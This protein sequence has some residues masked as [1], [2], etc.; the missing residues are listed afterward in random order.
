MVKI[1]PFVCYYVESKHKEIFSVLFPHQLDNCESMGVAKNGTKNTCLMMS[2]VVFE[3][4]RSHCTMG[5]CLKGLNV[6]HCSDAP[7]WDFADYPIN[8]YYNS[9]IGRYQ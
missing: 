9:D 5:A 3:V 1:W 7:I 4:F 2:T 8:Q 6:N